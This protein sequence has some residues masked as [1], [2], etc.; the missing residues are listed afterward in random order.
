MVSTVMRTADD[1]AAHREVVIGRPCCGSQES[2]T[3]AV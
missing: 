1:D 2:D 3:A